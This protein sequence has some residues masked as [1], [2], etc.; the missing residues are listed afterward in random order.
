M[1]PV[2]SDQQPIVEDEATRRLRSKSTSPSFAG[3]KR[4]L[5][6]IPARLRNRYGVVLAVL[7]AWVML[8]ADNDLWTLWKN[9]RELRRM[10]QQSEWYAAE[11]ARTKEQ[12]AEIANDKELLEKFARERYFMK[13]ENED[14]FVLVPETR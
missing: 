14:I 12:L 13:R 11:I 3:M 8:F 9:H 7:L 6:R 1:D 2:A 10:K 5:Q 4:L